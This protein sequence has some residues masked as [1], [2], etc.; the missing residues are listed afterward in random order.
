EAL[1]PRMGSCGRVG[2]PAVMGLYRSAKAIKHLEGSLGVPVFEIPGLP[3]SIPGMRLHNMMVEVIQSQGGFVYNG[4]TVSAATTEDQKVTGVWS[5]ATARR[6]SHTAKSF[7]LAT[8]GIL[9]GGIS[10]QENGYAQDVIFNIPIDT[11]LPRSTWFLDEFLAPGSHPIYT[12]GLH[13]D[14]GFH[15]VDASGQTIYQNLY[16]IGSLLGNCDPIRERSLEGIALATGFKLG[17][18]LSASGKR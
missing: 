17:E 16:A 3:P 7:V 10:T 11:P 8:G 6:K 18:N 5:E 9:G 1:K 15:P 4:M 14:P 2:F 12:R 13:V